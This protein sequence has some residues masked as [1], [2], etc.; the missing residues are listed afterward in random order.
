MRYAIEG[1]HRRGSR[2]GQHLGQSDPV[3]LHKSLPELGA[4]PRSVHRVVPG[5]GGATGSRRFAH[6]APDTRRVIA[7][8]LLALPI[9]RSSPAAEGSDA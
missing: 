7:E 8:Q 6:R 4:H 9:E 5:Q 2:R 1:A 3:T